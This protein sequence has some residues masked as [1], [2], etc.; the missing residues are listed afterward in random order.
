STLTGSSVDATIF[1]VEALYRRYAAY[2]ATVGMR[3]LGRRDEA[4]DLVQDVFFD[5]HRQLS[6]LQNPAAAK[7]WLRKIAVRKSI[8]RLRKRRVREWVGLDDGEAGE[9]SVAAS[10]DDRV[11][12]LQLY[13]RL[14][15]LPTQ[16]RVA[17]TL[18]RL[19]GMPLNDVAEACGKSLATVK[20]WISSAD[21]QLEELRPT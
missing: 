2:V 19:D 14:D 13:R 8:V 12:F 10:Q 17:W 4:E 3:L 9:P 21:E 1:N 11:A 18:R 5:V 20:R 7:A 6:G 16:Q 15:R